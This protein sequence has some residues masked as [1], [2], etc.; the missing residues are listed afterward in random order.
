MPSKS[1]IFCYCLSWCLKVYVL[2]IDAA[3]PAC[4]YPSRPSHCLAESRELYDH[5]AKCPGHSNDVQV[6][7]KNR[8]NFSPLRQHLISSSPGPAGMCVRSLAYLKTACPNFTKYFLFVLPVIVILVRTSSDNSAYV[9]PVLWRTSCVHM[10]GP[11]G[12]NQNYVWLSSLGV[13]TSR[14]PRRAHARC[15]PRVSCIRLFI[16]GKGKVD[17]ALI[18]HQNIAIITRNVSL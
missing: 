5:S 12:Q 14:R 1:W 15:H 9:L 6:Y 11:V 13:G 2:R 10:I 8:F 3:A 17:C 4:D 16:C 7:N 18:F